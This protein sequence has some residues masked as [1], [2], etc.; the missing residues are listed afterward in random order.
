M[1]RRTMGCECGGPVAVAEQVLT[2][3]PCLNLPLLGKKNKA[4][5]SQYSSI[6]QN[7]SF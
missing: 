2:N 5:P 3:V 4:C 1:K 7:C 6:T